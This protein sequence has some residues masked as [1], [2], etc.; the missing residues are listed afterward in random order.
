[1]VTFFAEYYSQSQVLAEDRVF[2]FFDCDDGAGD[3]SN[4]GE[5]TCGPPGGDGL[6][7]LRRGGSSGIPQ[8]RITGGDSGF[9]IGEDSFDSILFLP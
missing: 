2:T 7:A 4:R 3:L 1:N 6:D 5:F 9:S 8:G